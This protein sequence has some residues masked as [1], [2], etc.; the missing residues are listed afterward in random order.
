MAVFEGDKQTFA[1]LLDTDQTK[2]IDSAGTV[3]VRLGNAGGVEITA[4]G[5]SLGRVGQKGQVRTIEFTLAGFR[6]V[7]NGST[8]KQ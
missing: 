1:K 5:K 7:P 6:M 2:N 8:L 3:R 4:N